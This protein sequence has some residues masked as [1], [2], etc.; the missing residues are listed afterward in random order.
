MTNP[1]SSDGAKVPPKPFTVEPGHRRIRSFVLR[2]GRFTPAQQKAFDDQ[3]PRFGLDYSGQPRDFDAVFGRHAPRIVEIGFGNGEALRYSAALD[4]ARDHIGI[5]VHAPGVGRLLNALAADDAKNVRLYHHDAVEVLENEIA[6]ASLDEIRIYFPDPWHKKRHG[7]RR[8]VNTE[9][10]ALLV[11]K[12]AADGRLHLA[13]DWP[14]YA[15]QMWDVLDATPG[16]VNRAGPRG[17]P[18]RPAWRPQTHFETRGQRLGHP[19]FDLIYDR[20]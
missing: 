5:E 6:D 16:L 17:Q 13:T 9:F 1:F 8:L 15:E 19:V 10:A 20:N 12:L 14:D 18:P 11:R 3:W 2:Q 7:K 4:P